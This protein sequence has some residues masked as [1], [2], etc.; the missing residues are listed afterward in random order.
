MKKYWM[1]LKKQKITHQNVPKNKPKC[2]PREE[3]MT[4]EIIFSAVIVR[5][6]PEMRNKKWETKNEKHTPKWVQAHPKMVL[7][8][9]ENYAENNNANNTICPKLQKKVLKMG[10][11]NIRK[12]PP[13][14]HK[15][16]PSREISDVKFFLL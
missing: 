11:K 2:P 13:K 8:R 12:E 4:W 10:P 16:A 3:D 7:N 9:G 6:I 5:V 14:Y 15:I 1:V